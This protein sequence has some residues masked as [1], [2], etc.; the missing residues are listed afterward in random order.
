MR[1]FV[2]RHGQTNNNIERKMT[3][4]YDEDINSAGV[5]QA[6]SAREQIAELDY[7][8][9]I[10]SPLLRAKHTAEIVNGRNLP[11]IYDDRLQERDMGYLT[12]AE[13]H[14][15]VDGHD[16]WNI[17]PKK[18]YRDAE[19]LNAMYAR[20]GDFYEDIKRRYAK[21]TILAVTHD[22]FVRVLH[23]YLYGIPEHGALLEGRI[24]NCEVREINADL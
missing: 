17:E 20:A 3:G 24:R 22:G 15:N 16:F 5:A 18:D 23:S 1:L 13:I 19:P 21:K 8:V 6:L 9:I 12:N 14:S 2:M 7:D 11:I 10:A 4:R